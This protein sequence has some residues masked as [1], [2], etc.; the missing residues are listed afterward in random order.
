MNKVSSKVTLRTEKRGRGVIQ[1]RQHLKELP[2][3]LQRPNEGA[4]WWEE[5]SHDTGLV[6]VFMQ[7][8]RGV[9]ADPQLGRQSEGGRSL[10]AAGHLHGARQTGSNNFMANTTHLN[11]NMVFHSRISASDSC[12]VRKLNQKVLN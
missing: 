8:Y 5:P 9:L 3:S 7:K 2:V 12:F 10:P 1:Q 4:G 6:L 11:H